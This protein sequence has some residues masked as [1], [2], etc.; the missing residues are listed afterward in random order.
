MLNGRFIVMARLKLVVAASM[1][2]TG[3]VPADDAPV[4]DPGLAPG[5]V[6]EIQLNALQHNDEPRHDA[7][8]VRTW[9]FAHPANKIITG[10]LERF[11]AMI[12]GPGYRMLVNHREHAIAR[13]VLTEEYALFAVRIVP[14]SG[15]QVFYQ[16]K[17]EKVHSGP[18]SGAW[19]TVAV[20]PPIRPED[21]I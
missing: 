21:S 4:P 20:S 9:A 3:A 13:I 6:V 10:P 17:L 1:F 16:W 8:I 15:A 18:F 7:G 19:M 2:L 5:R 11:K 12:K 14:A